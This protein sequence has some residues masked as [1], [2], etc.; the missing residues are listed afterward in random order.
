MAN[1]FAPRHTSADD[2]CTAQL[3]SHLRDQCGMSPQR[4]DGT[5][6][7]QAAAECCGT[8]AVRQGSFEVVIDSLVGSS[9]A[10]AT[11]QP[12]AKSGF[13]LHRQQVNSACPDLF[14]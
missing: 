14:V 3:P 8:P 5:A 7:F 11:P 2:Q 6:P 10:F 1:L 9:T 12:R 13:A 4:V